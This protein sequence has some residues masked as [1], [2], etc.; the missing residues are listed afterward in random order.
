MHLLRAILF[1][2]YQY[3]GNLGAAYKLL[4]D[5]ENHCKVL[6]VFPKF[7]RLLHDERLCKIGYRKLV[8]GSYVIVYT[9]D[10]SARIARIVG[11]FHHRQNYEEEL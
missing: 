3:E 4:A 5:I 7:G 9:L 8:A 1:E 2:R 10:D 6:K 11:V